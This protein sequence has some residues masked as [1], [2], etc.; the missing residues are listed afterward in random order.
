MKFTYFFIYPFLLGET[1]SRGETE[2]RG[3]ATKRGN[4][5]QRYFDN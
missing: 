2:G 3:E 1:E 4:L 5:W